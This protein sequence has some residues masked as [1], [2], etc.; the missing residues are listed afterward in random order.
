MPSIQMS[1]FDEA[2]KLFCSESSH[3]NHYDTATPFI[4]GEYLC[5]TNSFAGICAKVTTLEQ[6]TGASFI[7]LYH[8]FQVTPS[9][10]ALL[11]HKAN[12]NTLINIAKLEK[13]LSCICEECNGTGKVEYVHNGRNKAT[14]II[15]HCPN[16][17]GNAS[18]MGSDEIE[19]FRLKGKTYSRSILSLLVKACKLLQIEDITLQYS[20]NKN[21]DDSPKLP[22]KRA[23]VFTTPVINI[24]L[25]PCRIIDKRAVT[26]IIL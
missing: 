23:T 1:N 25:M 5:A 16:C 6:V 11:P 20:Y 14:K 2:F 7:D 12:E 22:I 9:F 17:Q 18:S 19:V 21:F 8:P 15:G 10:T 26:D 4:Q 24:L 13:Q 3:M